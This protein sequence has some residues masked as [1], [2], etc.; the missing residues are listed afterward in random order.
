MSAKCWQYT[1]NHKYKSLREE[2][3]V[4]CFL[5][6]KGVVQQ[7]PRE[8]DKNVTSFYYSDSVLPE[9]ITHYKKARPNTGMRGITLLHCNVS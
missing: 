7:K 2:G 8:R 5:Q 1:S 6:F 9:V 4:H 3:I